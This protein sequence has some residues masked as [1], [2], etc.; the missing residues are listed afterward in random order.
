MKP[1]KSFAIRPA[2]YGSRTLWYSVP[3][4]HWSQV[5]G[6]CPYGMAEG[7]R[8]DCQPV[9]DLHRL[10]RG[11]GDSRSDLQAVLDL[12]GDCLCCGGI[13]GVGVDCSEI[14]LLPDQAC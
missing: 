13:P 10:V 11:G 12:G 9:V 14:R 6:H 7:Y 2:S 1:W 8:G 4:G 3:T 5:T